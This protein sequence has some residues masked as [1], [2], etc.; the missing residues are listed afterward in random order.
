MIST[1]QSQVLRGDFA[2]D[3]PVSYDVAGN[4]GLKDL[5][6]ELVKFINEGSANNKVDYVEELLKT[7]RRAYKYSSNID[8]QGN[9]IQDVDIA[10]RWIALYKWASDIITDNKDYLKK[11]IKAGIDMYGKSDTLQYMETFKYALWR[12]LQDNRLQ[13]Y[14]TNLNNL[15]IKNTGK[16]SPFNYVITAMDYR[17]S[18][19]VGVQIFVNVTPKKHLIK[20]PEKFVGII[21]GYNM[22]GYNSVKDLTI[23]EL[24]TMILNFDD[25]FEDL[26]SE[27]TEV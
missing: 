4:R 21:H 27:Y 26:V 8:G 5:S 19:S 25:E 24:D 12:K 7:L 6:I 10:K 17:S 18:E 9:K 13:H 23:K 22:L 15:P 2:I 20:V 1:I 14:D 11:E 16:S 3:L